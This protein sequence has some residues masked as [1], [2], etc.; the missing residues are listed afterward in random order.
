M[1]ASAAPIAS[2]RTR[3][4]D[5]DT[6]PAAEQETELPV[7]RSVP[8]TQAYAAQET[9]TINPT[10]APV[11][12]TLASASAERRSA[13]PIRARSAAAMPAMFDLDTIANA[14]KPVVVP[15][16]MRLDDPAAVP[17]HECREPFRCPEEGADGALSGAHPFNRLVAQ[18]LQPLTRN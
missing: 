16:G 6:Q 12:A 14:A 15:A 1:V 9:R 17:H 7:A 18:N 3:S 13:T 5:L 10:A 8:I 2:T 11:V 4:P